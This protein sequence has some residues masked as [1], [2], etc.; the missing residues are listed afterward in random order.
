MEKRKLHTTDRSSHALLFS[1]TFTGTLNLTHIGSAGWVYSLVSTPGG[2]D[3]VAG[4]QLSAVG[5][6]SGNSI[7]TPEPSTLGLLGTSLIG[8]AGL[9]R[10]KLRLG[11]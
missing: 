2:R 4:F 7:V 3:V 11:T 6:V 5:F 1:G 8:L 9:V 10:R